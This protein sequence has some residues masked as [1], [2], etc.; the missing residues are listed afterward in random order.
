MNH[1]LL[2]SALL[3]NLSLAACDRPTVITVPVPVAVPGPAGPAGPVGA[4]GSQGSTG[5]QGNQ[6]NQGNDGNTGATGTTG[7]GT[8]VIVMPPASAPA[9]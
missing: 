8:T 9:N 5:Y 4:T 7:D 2:L 1:T 3:A 6:G